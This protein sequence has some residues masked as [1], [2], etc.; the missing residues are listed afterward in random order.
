MPVLEDQ[1]VQRG[2]T[3]VLNVV[4]KA[5]RIVSRRPPLEIPEAHL[6]RRVPSFKRGAY[7]RSAM[8][9][10]RDFAP[11]DWPGAPEDTSR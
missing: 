9:T 8:M 7:P 5:E 6:N 1:I 2:A 4:Y 11:G 10:G 3:E